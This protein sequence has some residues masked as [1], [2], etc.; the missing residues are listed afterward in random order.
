MRT[1]VESM[2][3]LAYYLRI[4]NH[5]AG[6]LDIRSA[7][8]SVKGEIDSLL[9]LDHLDVC[10]ID[11]DGVWN[12]TYETGLKTSW[13]TSRALVSESPVRDVLTGQVDTMITANAMT[14]E[15]YVFDGALSG[16]IFQHELRSRV[17]ISMK[18]L[19]KT[20]GSLNC[21]SMQEGLYD[22]QS[23]QLIR[24][25]ADVLAPYF[26]A[27]RATEIARREALIRSDI[28]VREEGLRQGA[29]SLTEA[30]ER[31]RQRIGMDLHDQ[32]LA[33]LTRI[34]RDLSGEVQAIDTGQ[35]QRRVQD[36]IQG[37]RD[38]IDTTIPSILE[39]FG[40]VHAVQTHLQ[41]ALAGST[42]TTFKVKVSAQAEVDA[43]PDTVQISLFRIAQEAINN[44]V[45]H[46]AASLI[47]V[48]ITEDADK[49]LI[50]IVRDDGKAMTDHMKKKARGGLMHMRTRARLIGAEFRIEDKGGTCIRV[51]LPASAARSS[52][53]RGG[54]Q[55]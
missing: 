5:L 2:D 11:E 40:F 24:N 4:S 20:V 37:L 10:L 44:A 16:P 51:S 30:L 33:D 55:A 43:L 21:S 25:I 22:E 15:R 54:A 47:E 14:D 38:I 39:L 9:P 28:Q 6:K 50:I 34:S 19:G 52:T 26:F 41:K 12:T 29:L 3:N 42:K 36:C 23:A 35:L 49:R 32:T 1:H 46:A 7:L 31:E 18:V 45:L 17:N 27:L 48:E 13:S 8:Q 53:I